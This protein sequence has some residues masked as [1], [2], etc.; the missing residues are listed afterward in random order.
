M[1]LKEI[2][3]FRTTPQDLKE[4]SV[5]L[6]KR[7]FGEPEPDNFW[8][9]VCEGPAEGVIERPWNLLW[10]A[11]SLLNIVDDICGRMDW[12]F[13]VLH[14]IR[15]EKA[16]D[17]V[18]YPQL[19]EDTRAD[20]ILDKLLNTLQVQEQTT[21]YIATNEDRPGY[22]DLLKE[23]YKVFVRQDFQEL[24]SEG[25]EWAKTTKEIWNVRG[26]YGKMETDVTFDPLME[27][28]VDTEVLYR[29]QRKIETFPDLT[30]DCKN[31]KGNC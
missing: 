2:S 31:G 6:L 16:K 15:G 3:D 5:T 28:M 20:R 11:K 8:Y 9:R 19:D 21:I 26:E 1:Q 14:V 30:A 17:L 27:L 24:W 13:I 12:N 29:A 22:F 18:Q 10:K 23:H 25:S 7:K 4:D